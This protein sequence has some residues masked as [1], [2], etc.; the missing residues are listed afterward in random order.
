MLTEYRTAVVVECWQDKLEKWKSE[1]IHS[2]QLEI[3]KVFFCLN[4][5]K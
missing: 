4:D 5:K 1:S 2:G 3:L